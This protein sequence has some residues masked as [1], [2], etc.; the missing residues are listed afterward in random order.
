MSRGQFT[1]WA[2]IASGEGGG[3]IA[4]QFFNRAENPG[5]EDRILVMNT[6]RNDIRNTIDRI[7]ASIT[8][9]GDIGENHALEFGDK[10]G[11]GN[12]YYYGRQAAEQDLD[13]ITSHIKQTFTTADAFL[14]VATLGGGTGN[15]S[16]PFVVDQ[17]KQ[18]LTVSESEPWMDSVIHVAMAVWPYYWEPDQRHFNAV[19]GLSRLLR[20]RDG[21]QNADMVMLAANSHL[22]AENGSDYDRVN[23]LIIEAVDLMIGAGRETHGVIDVEDL[24]TI[25]RQYGSYHFTPAVAT[26]MN[27]DIYEL[28]Y[29]FD[30]AAENPFVPLDVATSQIVFPVVRAP[31]SMI[32]N[33]DI[34]EPEVYQ[35]FNQWQNKH[36][37]SVA[38]Q[39]SL[40]PKRGR[41]SDVDVLLLL[42]GF[43]LSPLLN[44]SMEQYEQVRDNLARGNTAGAEGLTEREVQAVLDNLADYRDQNEG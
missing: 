39:A 44:H 5:I 26:E 19:S 35:A 2:V 9:T 7:D 21:G 11:A 33:G 38:G 32:D 41:G 6:N 8:D 16:I 42:G 22:D 27:G 37:L 24:V 18:G 4:S 10:Q 12:S 3:R 17:F 15:G 14:Y 34:T 30:K 29:M 28:E 31:E 43:D 36:D 25:P 23:E 40:T 1:R 13:R 20:N